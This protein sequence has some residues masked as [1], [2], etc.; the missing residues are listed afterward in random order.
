MLNS[1]EVWLDEREIVVV[2]VVEHSHDSRVV[3]TR[4]ENGE[5]VGEE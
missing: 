5:E 4:G 3:D 2:G 1:D